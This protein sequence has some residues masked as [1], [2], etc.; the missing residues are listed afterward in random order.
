MMCHALFVLTV[1]RRFHTFFTQIDN[2]REPTFLFISSRGLA[3]SNIERPQRAKDS[4]LQTKTHNSRRKDGR[5]RSP[6]WK[7]SQSPSP[8]SKPPVEEAAV[9]GASA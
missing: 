6:S 8:S 5:S 4:A 1:L 9:A 7:R 3:A 2:Y